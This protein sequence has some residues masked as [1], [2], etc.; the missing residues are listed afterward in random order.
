MLCLWKGVEDVGAVFVV[1]LECP[2]AVGWGSGLWWGMKS[3]LAYDAS[4]ARRQG[5][6]SN[7]WNLGVHLEA[8][9]NPLFT[10]VPHAHREE[11]QQPSSRSKERPGRFFACLSSSLPLCPFPSIT[12]HN[13]YSTS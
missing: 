4:K 2:I 9:Y 3:I 12:I 8:Y 11:K 1:E 13:I 6:K 10:H 7:L 5:A